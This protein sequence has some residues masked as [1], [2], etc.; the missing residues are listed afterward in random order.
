MKLSDLKTIDQI[1]AEDRSKNPEFAAEWDR[2]AFARQVAIT[3]VRYRTE[4]GLSQRQLATMTGL[5]QP[6]IARLEIGEG[7]PSL[8]TLAKLSRATGLEFQLEIAHGGVVIPPAN[9]PASKPVST[10]L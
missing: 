5:Q 3:I 8:S 2:A 9:R 1:I 4:R 6:A 7:T 10:I